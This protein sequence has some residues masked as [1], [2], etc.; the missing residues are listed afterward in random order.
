MTPDDHAA[1]GPATGAPVPEDNTPALEDS[2]P[3]GAAP[4]RWPALV[5]LGVPVVAVVAVLG[6]RAAGGGEL[7]L[8]ATQARVSAAAA[9]VGAASGFEVRFD[10]AS[11][12][13]DRPVTGSSGEPRPGTHALTVVCASQ[14]G[15][16]A[17]LT[18]DVQGT[19]V[20][21]AEVACSDGADPDAPPEVTVVGVADLGAGWVV[22]VAG[23]TPAALSVLLS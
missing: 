13:P 9:E 4:R 5:A 20:A 6:A 17:H 15:A 10:G 3:G 2:A 22:E 7:N 1:D 11:A 18:V 12:G 21:R 16:P 14:R 23:E 8:D 19:E